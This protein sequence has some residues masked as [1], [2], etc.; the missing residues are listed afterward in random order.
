MIRNLIIEAKDLIKFH[1]SYVDQD[2]TRGGEIG[3]AYGAHKRQVKNTG[4]PGDIPQGGASS[5]PPEPTP[6]GSGDSPP[7]QQ[8]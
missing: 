4:R 8:L 7:P 5:A 1:R 3:R 2:S 6:Y